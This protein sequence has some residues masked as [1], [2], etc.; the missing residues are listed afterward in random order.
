MSKR[1]LW[2]LKYVLFLILP[3]IFGWFVMLFMLLIIFA[4]RLKGV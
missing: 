3:A 1:S 4:P 2:D